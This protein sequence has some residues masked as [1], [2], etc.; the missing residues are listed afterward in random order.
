MFR[1]DNLVRWLLESPQSGRWCF[2]FL[3][4]LSAFLHVPVCEQ[5]SGNQQV[6]LSG[7]GA[8]TAQNHVVVVGGGAGGIIFG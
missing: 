2:H 1:W 7:N 8:K 3:P 4:F 6:V 5:S